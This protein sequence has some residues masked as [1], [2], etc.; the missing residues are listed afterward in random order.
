MA[1]EW[2]HADEAYR[3]VE[4]NIRRKPRAWLEVV[5]A[6]WVAKDG[7]GL[8]DKKYQKALLKAKTLPDETLADF[9]WRK[10]EEHRTCENGGHRAHACPFGCGPHL[11]PMRDDR[12]SDDPDA[13]VTEDGDKVKLE[14]K[15][16]RLD[17]WATANLGPVYAGDF[18]IGDATSIKLGVNRLREAG[19][20][21]NT[22]AGFEDD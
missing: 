15:T 10:T 3:A 19:F 17:E 4:A 14:V 12:V 18:L 20:E 5:Y 9:V 8:D 13:V 6:E 2:S 1:W 7:I 16:K 11:V 21:V 22:F